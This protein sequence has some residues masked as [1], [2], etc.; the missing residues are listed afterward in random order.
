MDT[1]LIKELQKHIAL[2]KRKKDHMALAFALSEETAINST[3]RNFENFKKT[4]EYKV[5]LKVAVARF[6]NIVKKSTKDDQF[7]H[8]DKEHLKLLEKEAKRLKL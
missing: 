3:I 6:R 8:E 2:A 7:L 5:L 4:R 1:N